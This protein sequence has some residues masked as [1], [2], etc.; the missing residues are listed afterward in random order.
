MRA[1]VAELLGIKDSPTPENWLQQL[2][3]RGLAQ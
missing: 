1:E 3:K 2:I